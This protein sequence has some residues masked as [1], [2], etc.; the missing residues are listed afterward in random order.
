MKKGEE[1]EYEKELSRVFVEEK[2]FRADIREQ[3]ACEWNFSRLETVKEG[4]YYDN[5]KSVR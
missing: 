1:A 4:E 3:G 2:I 5:G